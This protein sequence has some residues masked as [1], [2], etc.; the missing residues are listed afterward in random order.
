M[1]MVYIHLC[2]NRVRAH[3]AG[4]KQLC[5]PVVSLQELT[6]VGLFSTPSCRSQAEVEMTRPHG[7]IPSTGLTEYGTM[8][9][10]A[11]TYGIILPKGI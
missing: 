7:S 5:L 2:A 4:L 10:F 3:L 9:Q 1:S 6:V 11:T 8:I